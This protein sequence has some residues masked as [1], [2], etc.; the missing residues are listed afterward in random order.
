MRKKIFKSELKTLFILIVFFWIIAFSLL[1]IYSCMLINT[2][3]SENIESNAMYRLKDIDSIVFKNMNDVE[4]F[5]KLVNA[6]K[7]NFT[8]FIN[9]QDSNS[10]SAEANK[11]I[12][13]LCSSF[14][15]TI[16][17]PIICQV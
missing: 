7:E 3:K 14:P 6:D 12:E 9:N 13:V 1:A 5:T 10:L 2:L 16:I 11:L 4:V 8:Q 17:S 15:T